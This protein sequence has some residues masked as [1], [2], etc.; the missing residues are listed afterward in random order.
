[1]KDANIQLEKDSLT[2]ATIS[3]DITSITHE[4]KNL[5]NYLKEKYFFNLSKYTT[6]NYKTERIVSIDKDSVN[7]FGKLTIIGI[8]Q[9]INIPLTITTNGSALVVNAKICID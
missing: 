1:M 3:I 2:A 7:A 4:D 8:T 6:K 9:S 5:E